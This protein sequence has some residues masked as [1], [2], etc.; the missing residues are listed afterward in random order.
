MRA[1]WTVVMG[2]GLLWGG[3]WFVGSQ[4]VERGAESWFAD[5]AA[6]GMIATRDTLVVRGF[7]NRFD[8][9]VEGLHLADPA[10]G[11]GW[12]APFVQI[13]SLTYKPW[14]VIAALPPSQSFQTP[15]QDVTL[16]SD[17]LQG[18][19]VVVPGTA[20]ALD[21]VTA[22]GDGLALRSSLGWLLAAKQARFGTRPDPADANAHEIG[23][24]VSGLV[25]DP[26]LM[27]VL[28]GQTNLPP[29]IEVVRLDSTATLSVP[30]DRY[31]AETT[32]ALNKLVIREGLIRWGSLV[33]FA[34]GSVV[35][36]AQGFAEGRI[37]LRIEDWRQA[38]A[39]AVAM[40]VIK[41]EI[42]PTLDQAL[43]LLAQQSGDPDV[44][45]L[46]LS[47]QSGQVSLGPIPLGRG[48]QLR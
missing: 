45:N 18:S 2:L 4:A 29:E 17:K 9:T 38:L 22:V 23:F 14:H 44:L 25:P 6:Q 42:A 40:G 20:L 48:P 16:T 12:R 31:V 10:S 32:P 35:P 33:F 37:D 41:P 30:L 7:P 26:A 43:G 3:Y 15:F 11:Y 24:E 5:Q 27:K 36:D 21:R 34:K 8:L 19:V 28:A 47:F 13:F 1:L 46:P 39:A